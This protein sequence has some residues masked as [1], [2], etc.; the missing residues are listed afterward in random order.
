[1]NSLI[2]VDENID[3]AYIAQHTH[4]FN[5]MDDKEKWIL[6]SG[7][8]VEDELRKLAESLKGEHITHSF[9]IDPTDTFWLKN[10][11]F[12]K[13]E[14]H[15]I[16]THNA[17]KLPDLPPL[18]KIFLDEFKLTSI[19]SLRSALWQK[20]SFDVQFDRN[21]SF[22]C[23]WARNV[24][25]NII[26]EMEAQQLSKDHLESWYISHV[27]SAF[28]R[29]FGNLDLVEVVRGESTSIA[30]TSRRNSERTLEGSMD[31]KRKQMGHRADFLVRKMKIEYAC[32]EASKEY[33]GENGTK[34]M[35]ERSM[36]LPKMLK[37]QF[38]QLAKLCN[39]DEKMIRR[40]STIGLLHYGLHTSMLVMDCPAGYVCRV[41]ATPTFQ[42][43]SDVV[44]FPSLLSVI[45]MT[46]K[47]KAR[48]RE[49]IHTIETYCSEA[50][51]E[52]EDEIDVITDAYRTPSPS[53][54][55]KRRIVL[56]SCITTPTKKPKY[57]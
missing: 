57:Q 14:L 34:W 40:I 42:I 43:P 6:R 4:D 50:T 25:Y 54:P 10:D 8:V 23:D 47:A 7:K 53:L 2:E 41:L 30:S 55:G 32:G 11:I 20:R 49:N 31:L 28:D 51:A 18:F 15:E 13:D 1:M 12:T 5:A 16:T 9:I 29:C 52:D 38:L 45:K 17:R 33:A 19:D 37:D 24:I 21:T 46:W 39:N 44:N 22:D 36:K 35:L 26:L 3:E 48:I 56:P 27:W